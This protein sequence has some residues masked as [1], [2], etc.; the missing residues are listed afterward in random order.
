VA[1]GSAPAGANTFV[2]V[3]SALVLAPVAI[4]AVWFGGWPFALFWLAA[5]VIVLWEWAVIVL[6]A[7][8]LPA[9][10]RGVWLVAGF[11]Y[12]AVLVFAPALLRADVQFGIHAILFL[13]AVVWTTD[14]LGYFGGRMLGGK[15][16][17]PS[18]SP[19][20]TWSGAICGLAGSGLAAVVFARVAMLPNMAA[21]IGVA[22]MLSIV[23]QLGDLGESAFKRKFQTKDAGHLIPGHG[24]VMDRLDGF[25]AAA[26]CAALIG[27]ARGGMAEPARGLLV[28]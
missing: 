27:L 17:A 11:A 23:S 12:A 1:S 6:A 19:S 16:L 18:V 28:W 8:G 5:G 15:K 2:R 9:S 10:M 21:L 14:I 3:I 13:F 4:A 7:R 24:G 25:W 20:K 22:V 26:L